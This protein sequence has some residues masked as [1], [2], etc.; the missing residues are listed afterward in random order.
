MNRHLQ[1]HLKGALIVLLVL[2]FVAIVY[3]VATR[4]DVEGLIRTYGYLGV[5]FVMFISSATIILPA[6]G[7]AVVFT[8]GAFLNPYLVGLSAGIGAAFGEL[9]GYLAGYGGREAIADDNGKNA[10]RMKQVQKWMERNGFATILVFAL[11]PNPV[12]DL[13]GIA[14][15][16]MKYD[17]KKFL[18]AALIGN[19]I[20][21]T[22]VALAGG[23]VVGWLF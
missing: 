16:S 17:W 22:Y 11:L 5:A 4:G 15:G 1:R 7:L 18:L 19:V 9:T 8:A 2:A 10:K 23:K 3:S 21:A 6:P 12:F 13:V 20:K 14:A